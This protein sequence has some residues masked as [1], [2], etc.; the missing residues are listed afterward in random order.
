MKK[1]K[2]LLVLREITKKSMWLIVEKKK[3]LPK[4]VTIS[5]SLEG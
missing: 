3:N 5:L 2:P 4:L 1:G